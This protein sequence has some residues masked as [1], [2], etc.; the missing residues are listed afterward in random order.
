MCLLKDLFKLNLGPCR[1]SWYITK[2]YIRKI[3]Y[4]IFYIKRKIKVK[5]SLLLLG[6]LLSLSLEVYENDI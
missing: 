6:A 3:I 2:K 1:E 4:V 5:K